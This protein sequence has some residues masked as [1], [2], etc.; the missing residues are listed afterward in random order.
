MALGVFVKDIAA[1]DGW[2]MQIVRF[3][4][5]ARFPVH[6]HASPEFLFILEGELV[7]AGRRM[8]PGW[9]SVAGAGT[10]DEDVYSETGLCLCPRRSC[11]GRVKLGA[12]VQPPNRP[13]SGPATP[14]AQRLSFDMTSTVKRHE[15]LRIAGVG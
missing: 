10:I 4:P 7:Q 11:V 13:L 9:A 6:T 5:G 3:R 2:E 12:T 8:G 15:D 14:A 1:T